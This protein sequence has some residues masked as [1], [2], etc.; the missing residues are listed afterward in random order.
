AILNAYQPKG[1]QSTAVLGRI[2]QMGDV[3]Q[4]FNGQLDTY[5][6]QGGSVEHGIAAVANFLNMGKD[7]SA[8]WA[9]NPYRKMHGILGGIMTG[10]SAVKTVCGIVGSVCGKLGLILTVIGLLGMIFPPIGAAISGIARI[11]NV[12]GVI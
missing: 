7:V 11:L 10:L 9:T 8:V 3:A 6:A 12:I 5:I 2:K 1:Q 4:G